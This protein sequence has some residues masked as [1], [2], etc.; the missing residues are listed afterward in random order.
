MKMPEVDVVIGNNA[1]LDE[2]IW[3][4]IKKSGRSGFFG[5]SASELKKNNQLGEA[6][7]KYKEAAR[8]FAELLKEDPKNSFADLQKSRKDDP[9]APVLKSDIITR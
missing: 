7:E 6:K 8:M 9:L 3:G 2:S 4:E 5:E 1:K